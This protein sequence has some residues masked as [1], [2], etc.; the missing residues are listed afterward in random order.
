[1]TGSYSIERSGTPFAPWCIIHKGT[2]FK[3]P[4]RR[5]YPGPESWLPPIDVCNFRSR[6]EAERAAQ[7]IDWPAVD[8]RAKD[9][10]VQAAAAR[11]RERRDFDAAYQHALAN[12]R[13]GREPWPWEPGGLLHRARSV[14]PDP[15]GPLTLFNVAEAA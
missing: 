6:E 9:R 14:E 12:A 4:V 11:W 7:E 13:A 10:E 8:E 3:V 15:D 5:P 2:E 1:M